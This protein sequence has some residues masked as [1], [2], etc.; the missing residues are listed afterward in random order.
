MNPEE[1]RYFCSLVEE[2]GIPVEG[3]DASRKK[4]KRSRKTKAVAEEHLCVDEFGD[5]DDDDDDD[6]SLIHI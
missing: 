4:P 5:D 2:V 6:L 3:D 1:E